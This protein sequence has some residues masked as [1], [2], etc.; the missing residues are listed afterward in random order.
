MLSGSEDLKTF[1]R[2]I[3][4]LIKLGFSPIFSNHSQTRD[5]VGNLL[6][7]NV[8][9]FETIFGFPSLQGRALMK[10]FET[11][12]GGYAKV[13]RIPPG[14]SLVFFMGIMTLAT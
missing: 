4:M 7:E 9:G 12:R 3:F 5:L 11:T 13:I 2:L 10:R 14:G 1:F 6:N 8:A